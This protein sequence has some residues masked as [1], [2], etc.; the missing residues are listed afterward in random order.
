VYSPAR[1]RSVNWQAEFGH[2]EADLFRR[3]AVDPPDPSLRP[4]ILA[5]HP[6]DETIGA[7]ALL[8]RFPEIH[9]VY[10]TDGAPRDAHFWPP[11]IECSRQD[12]ATIRRQEVAKALAHVGMSTAQV[13]WLGAIDQE[14][15]FEVASLQTKLLEFLHSRRT[16]LLITHPY[17]GGHPDHDCA[18][19]IARLAASSLGRKAPVICEMTSYH[20]RNGQ[21]VTGDFL[22]WRTS[23]ELKFSLSQDDFR[24]KRR[25]MDD[26]KSQLLV[27]KNFPIIAERLRIAPAYDFSRPPHPGKLW[28]EGMGWPMTG[29]RWRELASAACQPPQERP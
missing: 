21:C 12:Y 5:A 15:I 26:Y 28:Y 4:I 29:A 20:A 9:V 13:S 1:H 24:R 19:L 22:D 25:M 6:D 14:A 27:L 23:S 7:S 11:N 17:E 10:L 16:D 18:A 3:L 8:A 2:S